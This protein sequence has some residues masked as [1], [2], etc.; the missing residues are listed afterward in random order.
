MYANTPGMQ[1]RKDGWIYVSILC[2]PLFSS[3]SL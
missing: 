1:V 3:F 2:V